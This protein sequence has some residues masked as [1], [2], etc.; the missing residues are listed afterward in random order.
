M[1]TIT[2]SNASELSAALANAVGGDTIQ[3]QAGDYGRVVVNARNYSSN[4][5]ITSADP[6]NQ[7]HIEE[8]VVYNS[9]NVSFSHLE[10]GRALNAGEP[11]YTKLIE[12]QNDSN[13]TFDSVNVHGSL[14]GNPQNDGWGI[15]AQ[16]VTGFTV[17][18]SEFHDL[19]R[20]VMMGPDTNVTITNN[21]IH[22]IANTG[23]GFAAIQN[24]V[25]QGNHLTDF[26]PTLGAH[27]DAIQFWTADQTRGSDNVQIKDNVLLLGLGV[28]TQGI[29]I[30]DEVGNLHNTN[31]TIDNNLIYS[32]DQWEGLVAHGADHFTITNNTV[33]SKTGDPLELRIR[34]EDAYDIHVHGNVTDHVLVDPTSTG[35]LDISNNYDFSAD[36][37]KIALIPNLNAG[38]AATVADFVTPGY[39]YQPTGTPTPAPAPAPTPTPTPAPAPAPTPTPTPA[40]NVSGVLSNALAAFFKSH[41]HSGASFDKVLDT[42]T[43]LTSSSDTAHTT[44]QTA[45][46]Y[47]AVATSA[48]V[49]HSTLDSGLVLH[50]ATSTM[51]LSPLHH[52]DH[53]T[54]M[55]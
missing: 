19:L 48:D 8:M 3:L 16:H 23:L 11:E 36:P 20:G 54:A 17:N 28:G 35:S 15:L 5:T 24:A 53:F 55:V 37:S 9:Q 43:S 6:A 45:T 50:N 12:L 44:T 7:A 18:N 27:P 4:V 13:I 21:N 29:F 38:A 1:T 14:D 30:Q 10:F 41:P 32:S 2:V 51:G 42:S 49:S 31:F 33:V 40:S 46:K 34:L 22:N 25:V 52:F 39:G 47:A 26:H